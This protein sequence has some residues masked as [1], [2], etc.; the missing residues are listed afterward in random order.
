MLL[1]TLGKATVEL[2]GRV[3]TVTGDARKWWPRWPRTGDMPSRVGGAVG[4]ATPVGHG[5]F[6]AYCCGGPRWCPHYA[7][8]RVSSL[9]GCVDVEVLPWVSGQQ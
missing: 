7:P 5:G 8:R 9:R 1:E 6:A 4:I 2:Q 3:V